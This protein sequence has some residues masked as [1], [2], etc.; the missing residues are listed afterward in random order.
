MNRT[1]TGFFEQYDLLLTP[2][3]ATTAFVAEGPPPPTINGQ[4][5]GP[6][7]FI[8]FTYPFNFT[9]HPAASLPAG[10][11]ASGLPI[12]LQAV[13]PRYAEAFLLQVSAAFE[14]ARPWSYP[15]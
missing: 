9:G 13:A 7:S 2:T 1:M 3:T 4:Q 6:S 5:V 14:A 15:D 11:S 8:P 10:L 12:G